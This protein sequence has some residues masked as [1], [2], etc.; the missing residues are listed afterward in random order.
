MHALPRFPRKTAL[1]LALVLLAAGPAPL[2]AWDYE[3]HRLVNL[4]A[5][6]SLPTNFPAWVFTPA[7]RERIAFLAGEPDRWRNTPD[8]PLKHQ[9]GP[10]HYFDL[11]LLAPHRL[12]AGTL[13]MF[14]YEFAFRLAQARLS[15]PADVPAVDPAKD[16]DR[17]KAMIGLLPWTI[18]EQAGKVKSAFS[19]LREFDT[20]GTP[21][22]V[23]NMRENAIYGMGILGHFIG[24]GAQPL[25]TTKHHHG[26]V[27]DNPNRYTTNYTIHAWIDGGYFAKYPI[28]YPRL[29]ARL[30]PA[31]SLGAS[32]N[33]FP[34]VVG[35]LEEQYREVEPL[36]RLEKEGKLSGH[37]PFSQEGHEFL[38]GQVLR[39]AQMLGDVWLTA[40]Q[41]APPDTFLRSALARRKL[42]AP[43]AGQ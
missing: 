24:D 6:E 34:R 8:L 10:D 37:L 11:D 33:L 20:A 38:S 31:R 22:E 13:S 43:A 40:W 28:D 1:A 30:R 35:W 32:T 27:G 17:T 3:G 7:A 25:H 16:A 41:Q 12:E 23:A 5:L 2:R 15:H 19:S 4:L 14:R 18:V 26:W 42:A 29:K 9:N 21:E 36:Y 39:A